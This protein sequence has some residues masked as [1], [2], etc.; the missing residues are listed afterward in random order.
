MAGNA[1]HTYAGSD[2]MIPSSKELLAAFLA[3]ITP[4]DNIETVVHINY[5]TRCDG[6]IFVKGMSTVRAK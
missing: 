3:V 6:T 5:A 2:C 4:G 1:S